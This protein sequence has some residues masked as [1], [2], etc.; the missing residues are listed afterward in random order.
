MIPAYTWYAAPAGALTFVNER[1]ADYLGLPKDHPLRFGVETGAAW[2]SH[3]PLLHP[4]DHDESGC[5][6]KPDLDESLLSQF[7]A[8]IFDGAKGEQATRAM[9]VSDAGFRSLEG[10]LGGPMEVGTFLYIAV[11]ITSALGRV[12]QH[13]LVHKDIKPANILVNPDRALATHHEQLR[14]WD[15]PCPENFENRAALVGAEIALIEVRARRHGVSGLRSYR[16]I[17]G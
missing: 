17:E 5:A 2:D 11:A 9:P 1:C 3:I 12:H 14:V 7:H 10:M 8:P 4:D 13:R 6:M 15:E 16:Q